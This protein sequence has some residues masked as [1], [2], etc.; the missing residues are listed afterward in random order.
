MTYPRLLW[1][2]RNVAQFGRALALGARSR[3]FKS[4][5]S[6]FAGGGKPPTQGALRTLGQNGVV[7][8]L[9]EHLYGMEKVRG[10]TPLDSTFQRG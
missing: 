2:H 7:A 8:Q 10:S 6:D 3:R 4:C 5:H 1:G 9:V